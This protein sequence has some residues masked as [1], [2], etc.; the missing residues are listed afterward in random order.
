MH[1][2]III[3]LST[4]TILYTLGITRLH[5]PSIVIITFLYRARINQTIL[6]YFA[7]TQTQRILAVPKSANARVSCVKEKNCNGN[8]LFSKNNSYE[9]KT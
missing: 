2:I 3:T 4:N 7:N 8:S 5:N 1:N 6:R 9:L